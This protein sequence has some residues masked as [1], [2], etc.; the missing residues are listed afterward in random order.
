[1]KASWFLFIVELLWNVNQVFNI[2]VKHSGCDP[3][4]AWEAC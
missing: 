2:K 4:H 1:M 3:A